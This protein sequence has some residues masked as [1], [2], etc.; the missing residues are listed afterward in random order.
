MSTYKK[1][2]YMINDKLKLASD[3]S[4]YEID[5]IYF[6]MMPYRALLLKQRYTDLKKEIPQQNFQV[7]CLDLDYTHDCL[8]GGTVKTI[9]S[10]PKLANLGDLNSELKITPIGDYFGSLHFILTQPNR[11]RYVGNDAWLKNFIYFAIGG[12]QH[13]YV[14]SGSVNPNY[15]TGVEVS[16]ILEDPRDALDYSCDPTTQD[17]DVYDTEFPLEE[18]LVAPLIEMIVD[19][20]TPD[21]YK[22]QDAVNNASDD[23]S[24]IPTS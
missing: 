18:D 5:H 1:I 8:I 13:L 20:L 15:L 9:K 4:F 6:L 23:L 16:V 7:L 2:A 12:D 17:C 19:S 10:L 11:L 21:V 24:G 22:P 14:K 3:D